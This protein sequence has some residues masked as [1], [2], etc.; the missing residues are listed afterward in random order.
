MEKPGKNS[1]RMELELF[2]LR[3]IA[4]TLRF[5]GRL[6]KYFVDKWNTDLQLPGNIHDWFKN[7]EL[8]DDVLK[9]IRGSMKRKRRKSSKDAERGPSIQTG[10]SKLLE[11]GGRPIIRPFVDLGHKK[12]K[13]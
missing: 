9:D 10:L 1:R 6:P 12:S 13:K 3:E 11:E 2:F 7:H 5:G 4:S 8:K